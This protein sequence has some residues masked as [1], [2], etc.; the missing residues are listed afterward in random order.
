MNKETKVI[1][2]EKKEKLKK[3]KLILKKYA[4]SKFDC[5]DFHAVADA[6]NDIREIDREISSL[7]EMLELIK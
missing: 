2:I 6:C 3:K 1:L 7:C 4:L 5:E